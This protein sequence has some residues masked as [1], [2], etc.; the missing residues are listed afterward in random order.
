M[1]GR[2]RNS[3]SGIFSVRHIAIFL[4]YLEA[5]GKGKGSQHLLCTCHGPGPV[6]L[7]S[8]VRFQDRLEL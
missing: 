5:E 3:L 8:A 6:V 2:P 4:L 1:N 7:G